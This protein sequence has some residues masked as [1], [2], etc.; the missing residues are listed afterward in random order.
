M[1][2]RNASNI[3]LVNNRASLDPGETMKHIPVAEADMEAHFSGE[4]MAVVPFGQNQGVHQVA[5]ACCSWQAQGA[6]V[7]SHEAGGCS[8]V[9]GG[10]AWQ[11][12]GP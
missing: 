1:V 7:R 5:L 11:M 12:Y 9:A 10:F 3:Q 4:G 2:I 6:A 8:S